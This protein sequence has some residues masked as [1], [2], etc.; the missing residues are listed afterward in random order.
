[1]PSTGLDNDK[2]QL[3]PTART[4]VL[5]MRSIS[6]TTPSS[7][8]PHRLSC[9]LTA[10]GAV[11]YMAPEVIQGRAGLASYGEAA[12]IYSLGVT[13]WDILHPGYEKF[14]Q[15]KNNHLHIF[16]AILDG[17]HPKFDYRHADR[18][19]EL[20]HVIKLAWQTEP[21]R[22]PSAQHLVR[23]LGG[24]QE[25]DIQS[26]GSGSSALTQSATVTG[27][28]VVA[29]MVEAQ[30]ACIHSYEPPAISI[31]GD[32]RG[33]GDMEAGARTNSFD[34]ARR[35]QPGH[36]GFAPQH[37]PLSHDHPRA[38]NT[39]PLTDSTP[40][41]SD[42]TG[43]ACRCRA[44][45]QRL[46]QPKTSVHRK[47]LQKIKGGHTTAGDASTPFLEDYAVTANLLIVKSD[48]DNNS[49]EDISVHVEQ[50]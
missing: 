7:D 4:A 32:T 16:E 2:D 14:P 34:E 35:S 31:L 46:E 42:T 27:N 47:I 6:L 40:I 20:R 45:S 36:V 50:N 18:D 24:I 44:L 10:K 48:D 3:S 21:E 8:F 49:E 19:V 41:L 26:S 39:R 22:R 33:N 9:D 1:M 28:H 43:R 23:M 30:L 12:D 13:F 29:T 38:M 11:D 37:A 17:K 25:R 15:L 5:R